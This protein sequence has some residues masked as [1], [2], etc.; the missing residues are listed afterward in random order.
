MPVDAPPVPSLMQAK[1]RI[2]GTAVPLLGN[3]PALPSRAYL[4]ENCCFFL[5]A[6]AGFLGAA[7]FFERAGAAACV[8]YVDTRV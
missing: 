8:R 3:M 7:A 5:G 6:A 4:I 2:S 1:Q